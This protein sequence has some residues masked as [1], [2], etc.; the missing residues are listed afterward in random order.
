MKKRNL[1]ILIS[2]II[3][4]VL[5]LSACKD[6]T[7]TL[8]KLN[9]MQREDYSKLSVEVTTVKDGLTLEGSYGFTVNGDKTDV[10]YAYDKLN[11]FDV[12]GNAVTAPEQ[13]KSRLTGTAVVKD[14]AVVEINGEAIDPQLLTQLQSASFTFRQSLFANVKTTN[15]T[16]EAD[17]VNPKEFIGDDNFGGTDVKVRIGFRKSLDKIELTYK[18]NGASVSVTYKFEK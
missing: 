14:G 16:F 11:G 15:Y 7:E 10:T 13:F 5:C 6:N 12:S 1:L 8:R 9:T 3:V 18:Q 4:L 2:V 17:V